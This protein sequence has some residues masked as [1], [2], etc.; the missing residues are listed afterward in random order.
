[1]ERFRRFM[2]LQNLYLQ[3]YFLV[4]M[5]S[6][7][8]LKILSTMKKIFF[9]FLT[10]FLAFNISGQDF[11]P[12]GAEWHYNE[13]FVFSGDVDYI[14]L[15]SEKDT[16]INGEICRKITKRHRL[17]CKDRPD[18]EFLFSRNDTVFFLDTIFNEF[19]ILY[20]FNAQVSD[21]WI[22]KV[23]NTEQVVDTMIITVD[24]VSIVQINEFD[25]KAL[26]V[27]YD[28]YDE[29][30][31]IEYTSTI[32]EKIG[33]V[34]YMFNWYPADLVCDMN[35]TNGLRCYQDS[36]IGLYSTGMVDSCDYTLLGTGIDENV[37][38]N[39]IKIYPNPAKHYV[40]IEVDYNSILEAE[41]LDLNGRIIVTKQFTS[42][43]KLDLF[44][45]KS[46]VYLLIIRD[47]DE[48]IGYNKVI[49]E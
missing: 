5:R 16:L 27:T 33:D 48:V 6:D 12:I 9:I 44:N 26:H 49:I 14:K 29:D 22:I 19:Q 15:T 45:L 28:N 13:L 8:N 3:N 35:Y 20:D 46:G 2:L 40:D 34:L 39:L 11:A 23:K 31:P 36:V 21:S 47:K 43:L 41:L 42:S 30:Y 1:M 18:L 32:I 4:G 38:D 7:I 24:S 37:R 17:A 10:T 25:L